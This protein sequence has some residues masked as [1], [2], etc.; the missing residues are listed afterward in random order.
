MNDNGFIYQQLVEEK[1]EI[2]LLEVLP[3]TDDG[4]INCR[5]QTVSLHEHDF[6]ALSYQWGP[7]DSLHDIFVNG[8]RCQVRQ[9]L[10]EFLIVASERASHMLLW[11]DTLCINQT[12]LE[13]RNEHVR[14][15]DEIYKAS[16][17]VLSWLG[18]GDPDIELAF[19]LI[20]SAW[21]SP[22]SADDY[23]RLPMVHPNQTAES[24]WQIISKFC[25]LSYWKRVWVAQE[26][27]LPCS[28]YLLYGARTLSW[29]AFANFISLVDIR[30]NCPP[31]YAR[32]ITNSTPKSYTA[33][34]PYNMLPKRMEW[35]L[36]D[37]LLQT[38][39]E[40]WDRRQYNLFRILTMFGNRECTDP[41]DHIY[42]LL[43]LTTQGT[44]FP[45][46]YG[47]D[48]L[49]LFLTTFHFCGLA[50]YQDVDVTPTLVY[51]PPSQRALIRNAKY[52]AETLELIPAYQKTPPYL[53]NTS[54]MSSTMSNQSG[55]IDLRTPNPR[56]DPCFPCQ[57]QWLS[58]QCTII[59]AGNEPPVL[60]SNTLRRS[61]ESVP[62]DVLVHIAES[63]S[64]LMCQREGPD[65]VICIG[66]ITLKDGPHGR[67]FKI[68][69]P[70]QLSRSQIAREPGSV[71]NWKML[72]RPEGHLD[73][74]KVIILGI[75]PG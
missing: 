25:E 44:Q 21:L 75:S 52:L 5:L 40:R 72:V 47:I 49:E 59:V 36:G 32:L 3:N 65:K 8:Q 41:L 4:L 62:F 33:F 15:M 61:I 64:W 51:E 50:I 39:G 26:I 53:T 71:D 60:R 22:D 12:D 43:A 66:I 18:A 1:Q 42:A 74:L 67:G 6:V 68:L 56:A 28:N 2:R 7:A 55:S 38:S 46:K 73:W 37:R 10:W 23:D 70:G 63:S 69:E 27:L 58:L 45:V 11:V 34:K 20:S 30:Y 9:N 24:T 13:E 17:M 14:I 48:L 57:D 35:K 54:S 31:R 16:A 29:Q 19:E